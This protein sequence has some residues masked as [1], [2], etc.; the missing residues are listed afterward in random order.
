V[1]RPKERRI[2]WKH[3]GVLSALDFA[4]MVIALVLF[5]HAG[6][7]IAYI[8]IGAVFVTWFFLRLHLAQRAAPAVPADEATAESS[9]KDT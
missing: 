7:P 5:G 6:F 3:V 1:A 9:Q 4:A 2:V 8:L